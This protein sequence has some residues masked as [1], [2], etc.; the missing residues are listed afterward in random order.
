MPIV[1]AGC[2][3]HRQDAPGVVTKED[4]AISTELT[5]LRH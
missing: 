2:D 1:T 4:V 5:K 3:T